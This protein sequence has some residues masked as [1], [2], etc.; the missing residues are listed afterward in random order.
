MLK[1]EEWRQQG[2]VGECRMTGQRRVV[3]L[4]KWEL[5]VLIWWEKLSENVGKIYEEC[6]KMRSPSCCF[7]INQSAV[8]SGT[9]ETVGDQELSSW[10][11]LLLL[12]FAGMTGEDSQIPAAWDCRCQEALTTTLPTVTV[13]WSMYV[14][15]TR[16]DVSRS[17]C[18]KMTHSLLQTLQS[19]VRVCAKSVFVY[20]SIYQQVCS[21]S[22]IATH[23]C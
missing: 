7:N 5:Y 15:D 16:R 9:S 8:T 20:P 17:P 19:R 14:L 3:K 10:Y 6:L 2:A 21:N 12:M 22:R 23:W 11:W 18:I 13:S 1:L 4:D